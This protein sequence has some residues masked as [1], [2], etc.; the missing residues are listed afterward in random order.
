MVWSSRARLSGF[1]ARFG[2]QNPSLPHLGFSGRSV[3][4]LALEPRTIAIGLKVVLSQVLRTHTGTAVGAEK[5]T[6][7]TSMG[8]LPSPS[9]SLLALIALSQP[10]F[11]FREE[12]QIKICLF[13][14]FDSRF[15]LNKIY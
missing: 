11:N 8:S 1:R 5:P 15:G 7:W 12:R 3:H 9:Y 6:I 2:D 10:H 4:L 14:L 13:G